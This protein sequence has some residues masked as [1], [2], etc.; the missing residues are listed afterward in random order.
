MRASSTFPQTAFRKASLFVSK[1]KSI[2]FFR[3]GTHSFPLSLPFPIP[4]RANNPQS[5]RG[6]GHLLP[7]LSRFAPM[8]LGG[9]CASPRHSLCVDQIVLPPKLQLVPMP[10]KVPQRSTVKSFPGLLEGLFF[11]KVLLLFLPHSI[12]TVSLTRVLVFF[13]WLKPLVFF[14]FSFLIFRS[15][16]PVELPTRPTRKKPLP[17]ARVLA[18]RGDV[19]PSITP[20]R[21]SLIPATVVVLRTSLPLVFPSDVFHFFCSHGLLT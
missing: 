10:F 18:D 19:R 9:T 5:I 13:F 1:T 21:F 17:S 20:I 2:S 15:S 14:R 11:T 6:R 4:R 16:P 12:V 7:F 3:N 8:R